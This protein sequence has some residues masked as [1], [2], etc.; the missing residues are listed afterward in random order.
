MRTMSKVLLLTMRP[1]PQRRALTLNATA[2]EGPSRRDEGDTSCSGPMDP[3]SGGQERAC[4]G[5]DA[6]RIAATRLAPSFGPPHGDTADDAVTP[7]ARAT[8]RT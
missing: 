7:A 8:R 1:E 5:D 6:P 3:S 4:A 2:G